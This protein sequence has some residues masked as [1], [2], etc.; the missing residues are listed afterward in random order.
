MGGE[1]EREG[2]WGGV[3]GWDMGEETKSSGAGTGGKGALKGNGE[4]RLRGD[5]NRD[6]E[7]GW[8]GRALW[9]VGGLMKRAGS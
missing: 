1:I 5:G 8:E 4:M 2:K 6:G 3:L 7:L 9:R